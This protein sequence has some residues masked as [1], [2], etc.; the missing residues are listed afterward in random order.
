MLLLD[1]INN[2]FILGGF[3]RRQLKKGILNLVLN[4]FL[5]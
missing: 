1:K 2:S 4:F 3:S 5:I